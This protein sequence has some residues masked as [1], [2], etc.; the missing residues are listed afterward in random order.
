MTYLRDVGNEVM[1]NRIGTVGMVFCTHPTHTDLD[2]MT[3]GQFLS[4]ELRRCQH[5]IVIQTP[6]ALQSQ[7]M[8]VIVENVLQ[9]VEAGQMTGLLH[10]M[11]LPLS[12]TD[13]QEIPLRWATA[14]QFDTS[15][16]YPRVLARHCSR[17]GIVPNNVYD[18]PSAPALPPS[19]LSHI[20]PNFPSSPPHQTQR[21]VEKKRPQWYP[22]IQL[23]RGLFLLPLVMLPILLFTG[24]TILGHPNQ[25]PQ[26]T[27][28]AIKPTP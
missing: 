19:G 22:R 9:Q 11:A 10:V 16:D 6:E 28:N 23:R 24:S 12:G 5:L 7:R 25:S 15:Q 8:R 1:V 13:A 14:P 21:P 26:H 2:D 3:F 18:I 4:E 27:T 20:H 17:L